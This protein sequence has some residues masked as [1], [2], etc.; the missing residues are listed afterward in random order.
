MAKRPPVGIN[1]TIPIPIQRELRKVA[2]YAFDAQDNAN[3]AL[4]G[5]TTKVSKSPSDLLEVS[6]FVSKQVQANG[7]YPIN[8]TGLMSGF[9]GT[10]TFAGGFTV[11]G[12]TFNNLTFSSGS[13]TGVS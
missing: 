1:P 4:T 6:S 13:L 5:L 10:I 11:N 7:K 8:L 3:K 12:Q 9:S 2:N